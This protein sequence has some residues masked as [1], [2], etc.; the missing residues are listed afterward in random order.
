M[1]LSAKRQI[2]LKSSSSNKRRFILKGRRSLVTTCVIEISGILEQT[3]S[4]TQ[5]ETESPTQDETKVYAKNRLAVSSSSTTYTTVL[6]SFTP[7]YAKA[8]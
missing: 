4:P 8:L 3:E 7:I 5:D 2:A 6:H 1:R